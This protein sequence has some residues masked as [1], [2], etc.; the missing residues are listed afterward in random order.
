M[1]GNVLIDQS[2]R[3]EILL[4]EDNPSDVELTRHAFETNGLGDRIH[5][6]RDG[7]EALEYLFCTGAYADRNAKECPRLILLDLKLPKVGGFEVLRRIRADPSTR[8]IPVVA[9]TSSRDAR[10]IAEAYRLGVNSYLV[11]PVEFETFTRLA[12][13]LGQY[14][15]RTNQ[16][17]PLPNDAEQ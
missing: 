5:V 8:L 17:P 2:K 11:K 1:P 15:L 4:V 3:V 7:A 6:V 10:D 9:L 12:E 14:W 13:Q 16:G